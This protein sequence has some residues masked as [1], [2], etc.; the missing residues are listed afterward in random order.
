MHVIGR[1][2][3]HVT[4][5]IP[6]YITSDVA[7]VVNRMRKSCAEICNKCDVLHVSGCLLCFSC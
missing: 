5:H 1:S 2:D 6:Q 3:N 4:V 7:T